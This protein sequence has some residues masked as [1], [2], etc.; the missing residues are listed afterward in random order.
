MGGLMSKM[1]EP[2]SPGCFVTGVR[3]IAYFSIPAS[4]S[5]IASAQMLLPAQAAI[6]VPLALALTMP[7]LVIVIVPSLVPRLT[8]PTM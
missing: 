1:N 6:D 2:S 3:P 5:L 8:P 7:G 4:G